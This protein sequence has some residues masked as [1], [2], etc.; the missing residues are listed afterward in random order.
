MVT[1]G[2]VIFLSYL[3][4]D[5]MSLDHVDIYLSRHEKYFLYEAFHPLPIQLLRLTADTGAKWVNRLVA[6]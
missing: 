3:S 6:P 1:N 2:I 5:K 4:F